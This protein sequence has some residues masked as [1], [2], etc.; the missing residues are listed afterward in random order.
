MMLAR[1]LRYTG[2]VFGLGQALETV[3]DDRARPRIPTRA[4]WS[5]ALAMMVTRRGSLNA[6]ESECRLPK[7]LT[8][9]IGPTRP[10]ADTI[11]RVFARMD[12]DG[13]RQMLCG[14][15]Y[16]LRRNKALPCA[17]PVRA[18]AIDGHDFFSQPPSLLRG[19]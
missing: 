9:W 12:P 16:R 3:A 8:G 2:K 19:L 6:L 5:S 1:F 18:V 17:W 10:S 13:L 11:G 15:D 7:R 4:I 14:F